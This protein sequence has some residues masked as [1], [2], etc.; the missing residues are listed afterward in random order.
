M[1]PLS[2]ARIAACSAFIYALSLAYTPTSKAMIVIKLA[3]LG[4]LY[5]AG[6]I[7]SREVGRGEL[8]LIQRVLKK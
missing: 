2:L 1:P 4:L 3:L 5:V 8:Q 6:L 7:A